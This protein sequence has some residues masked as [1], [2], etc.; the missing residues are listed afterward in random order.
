MMRFLWA[1][2]SPAS[3][4]YNQWSAASLE[5]ACA[6]ERGPWFAQWLSEWSSGIILDAENLLFNIY[7]TWNRSHLDNKDL[8]QE[9]LTHLQGIGKYICAQDVSQYMA[10]SKVKNKYS[11]KKGITE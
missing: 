8:Q 4:V 2:T 7:G 9:L 6:M 11:M 1:Y 10:C 5:P 3:K